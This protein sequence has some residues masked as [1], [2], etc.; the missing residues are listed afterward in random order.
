MNVQ[1]VSTFFIGFCT[2]FYLIFAVQMLVCRK[3]RSRFQRV[4]G[5]ILAIWAVWNLKD[6]VMAFPGMY[7]QDVLD[8]I[9]IIDGW[10]ALTYM[11]FVF[12]ATQPGWTTL[13]KMVLPT[14]PFAIF[15][16]VYFFSP[17][18]FVLQLYWAF[19]WCFAWT[20]IFI[21][22]VRVRRYLRY[23][24]DNFSNIDKIDLSWIKPVFFFAII[25]QLAWLATSM[26]SQIWADI[27][28]YVSTILLWIVA[29]YYTWDFRPIKVEVE[30][31]VL[32]PATR[33]FAFAGKLEQIVEE[34][35]LY[36]RHDLT[37]SDL[38]LAVDSNRTYISSYLSHVMGESFYDYINRLRIQRKAI[39][40][41][42]EHPEY[43]LEYVAT[44]SGFSS[45]STFRRAF[46]KLMNQ[47]PRQFC[48]ENIL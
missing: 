44:E 36:L 35:E 2:A 20:V 41:M 45:I 39:P 48:E 38:A 42:K 10:S 46:T 33:E 23:E 27:V 37:V 24:H 16:I 18:L 32:L 13:R 43:T 31:K 1:I 30:D 7:R 15:T 28:Y 34:E 9:S 11:I 22:Y 8:W 25:S 14:L 17:T 29:L 19:L 26:L 21:A 3:S 12:E 5:I 6:I 4:T 40:L 47:T